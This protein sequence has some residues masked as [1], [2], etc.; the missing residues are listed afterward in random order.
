MLIRTIA[1]WFTSGQLGFLTM[2]CHFQ[3]ELFFFFQG[4][5]KLYTF[6][7]YIRYSCAVFM[8]VSR[9]AHATHTALPLG[10]LSSIQ[11]VLMCQLF[12]RETLIILR[13]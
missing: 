12:T 4:K 7:F 13:L 2:T 10:A 6:Y 1:N 11:Q 9:N 8:R 5:Q 3:C